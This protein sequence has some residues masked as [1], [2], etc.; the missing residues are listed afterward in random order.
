[1]INLRQEPQR[2][3]FPFAKPTATQQKIKD[4]V[5]RYSRQRQILPYIQ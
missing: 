2:W 1:M 3:L 4:P 5:M